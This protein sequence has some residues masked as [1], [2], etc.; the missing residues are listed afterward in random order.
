MTKDITTHKYVSKNIYL[1][2]MSALTG[3]FELLLL[4]SAYSNSIELM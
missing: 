2:V 3:F 4:D 1:I